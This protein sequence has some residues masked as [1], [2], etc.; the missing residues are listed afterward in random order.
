M[1]RL[2]V[3]TDIILD[4]LTKREPFY[5]HSAILFTLI[6]S[7]KFR[8]FVSSLI[9]SNLFYI[10]R[11]ENTRDKTIEI[12][13]KLKS[14]VTI[15]PVDKKIIES[16]LQSGFKDFEDAIQYYTAK[17]GKSDFIITRN[18]KDFK[19]SDIDVISAEDFLNFIEG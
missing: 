1:K 8:A 6:E 17:G 13:T 15:L 9:F 19:L 7:G 16:A 10:L 2:F 3:D 11:K 4:L 18:I 12:L 5:I 14:L